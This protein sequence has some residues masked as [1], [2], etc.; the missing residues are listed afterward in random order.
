MVCIWL[1]QIEWVDNLSFPQTDARIVTINEDG[2]P[3][4]KTR[5]DRYIPA[6]YDKKRKLFLQI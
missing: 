4:G 2:S 5:G 3:V 1:I 6:Y